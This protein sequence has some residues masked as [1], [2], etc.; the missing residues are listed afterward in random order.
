MVDFSPEVTFSTR[1]L[2]VVAPNSLSG[3][4]E[5]TNAS[6]SYGHVWQMY[7]SEKVKK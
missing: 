7:N 2:F 4:A 6:L 1:F 5:F 3:A